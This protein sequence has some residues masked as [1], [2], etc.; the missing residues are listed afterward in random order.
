MAQEQARSGTERGSPRHPDVARRLGLGPALPVEHWVLPILVFTAPE[1]GQRLVG[2]AGTGFHA[3]KGVFVTCWHCVAEELPPDRFYGVL[4]K[5][6]GGYTARALTSVEQDPAG[7][8][9]A[10]ARMV[11][12]IP[13][14]S[15]TFT[16]EPAC[17]L[18]DVC[19]FGYPLSGLSPEVSEVGRLPLIQMRTLKGYVVR[20][21]HHEQPGFGTA[22]SYELDMPAPEGLSGAPLMTLAWE[23]LGVVYGTVE[24]ATITEWASVDEEVGRTPEVQR[25]VSFAVAHH[26]DSL[27]ALSGA[28]T[29]GRTLREY[30][31]S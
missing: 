4:V 8:D 30:L 23:V 29:S 25:I 2:F 19:A 16:T 21:F 7:R 5:E 3:G 26:T 27:L 22:H 12:P 17:E 1:E 10:T 14:V 15:P 31:N 20:R 24:T 11:P 13:P 6:R 28:A 9:L 18:E